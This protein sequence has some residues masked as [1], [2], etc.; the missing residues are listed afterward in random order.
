MAFAGSE[1]VLRS[2]QG[3][4]GK[5]N[6]EI[7][8]PIFDVLAPVLCSN[9]WIKVGANIS[10]D[11]ETLYWNF[12]V[13]MCGMFSVDLAERVIQAGAISLKK[14]AEF[15]LAALIERYFQKSIDK[16]SQ[17]SFDL[18]T[19]LTPTQIAYAALDTRLPL[20]VRA[21]QMRVLERD[22]L[23][24]VVNIENE[25]I[26]TF[27]DMHLNGQRLD[28]ERWMLRLEAVNGFTSAP[29]RH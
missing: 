14:Y 15:S 29:C 22:Q 16:S 11:Y 19:P 21:V 18:C 1:D 7:Y 26:A 6:A 13:Q 3:F 10:F 24:T 25:A 5:N 8:R 17:Q 27:I 9:D 12:G 2:S 4:Y 20:A 28:T 23:L